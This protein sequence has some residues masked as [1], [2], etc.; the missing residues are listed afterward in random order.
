MKTN[1][2]PGWEITMAEGDSKSIG[3]QAN[4]EIKMEIENFLFEEAALLDGRA[5]DD[6]LDLIS[7]DI[8]YYMPVRVNC[9]PRDDGGEFLKRHQLAQFDETKDSLT[10]RVKRLGTGRVL[11]DDPPPRTHHYVSNIRIK[12]IDSETYQI[13]CLFI[14]RR[15]RLDNQ[16]DTFYGE[17]TDIL[18]R[19]E[20]ALGFE[21]LSRII[22]LDMSLIRSSNLNILF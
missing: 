2:A 1:K 14:V 8:E 3:S 11:S 15:S 9:D 17:R 10:T 4:S 21:I 18:R 22:R 20:N 19:V 12:E 16:E 13:D 7:E 5:F 6:W